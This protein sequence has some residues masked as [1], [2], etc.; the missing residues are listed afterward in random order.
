M[1]RSRFIT[2]CAVQARSRFFASRSSLSRVWSFRDSD[3]SKLRKVMARC[4]A[5][6]LQLWLWGGTSH[7]SHD[8]RSTR[9]RTQ[10]RLEPR[11]GSGVPWRAPVPPGHLGGRITADVR[12]RLA[13]ARKGVGF[14]LPAAGLLPLGLLGAPLDGVPG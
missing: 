6:G 14:G 4:M 2:T 5:Q 3:A 10:P 7:G 1:C 9:A 8:D 13:V 12:G 11:S